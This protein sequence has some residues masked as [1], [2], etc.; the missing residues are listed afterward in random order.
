MESGRSSQFFGIM[1]GIVYGVKH[2]YPGIWEEW[3]RRHRREGRRVET[4][5][6]VMEYLAED[7]RGSR[8]EC[9]ELVQAFIWTTRRVEREG[10][11]G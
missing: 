7:A 6:E 5:Q 8:M 2:S 1:I 11:V 10:V 4:K 9:V 3:W